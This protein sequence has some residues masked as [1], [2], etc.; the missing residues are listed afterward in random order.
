MV[1]YMFSMVLGWSHEEIQ[2][3]LAL[4][5]KQLRD[6]NVHPVAKLRVI[7]A[8]KPLDALAA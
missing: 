1:L 8:Q 7:Y 3:Y 6:R 2:V 4:L 5:R